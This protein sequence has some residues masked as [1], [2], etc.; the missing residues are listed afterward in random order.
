M[1]QVVYGNDLIHLF[2]KV[3]IMSIIVKSDFA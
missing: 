3:I 2:R 1:G